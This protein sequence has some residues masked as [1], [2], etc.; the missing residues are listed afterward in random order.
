MKKLFIAV[1]LLIFC[2]ILSFKFCIASQDTNSV[3]VYNK[4]DNIYVY[5]EMPENGMT[6]KEIIEKINKQAGK[7]VAIDKSVSLS[8]EEVKVNISN[9]KLID[10]LNLIVKEYNKNKKKPLHSF[11][12]DEISRC[13]YLNIRKEKNIYVLGY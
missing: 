6:I 8:T 4:I 2:I 1:Q 13:L 5:L 9:Y 11:D 12:R 10:A 3:D 7:Y